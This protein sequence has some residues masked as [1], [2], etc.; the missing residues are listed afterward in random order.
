MKC[1]CIVKEEKTM[2]PLKFG[3]VYNDA[4]TF[5]TDYT[6]FG[7]P[8]T[9]SEANCK[10]LFYLLYGKYAA[11]HFVNKNLVQSKLKIF[12]TIFKYGPTWEKKLEIQAEL[13]ALDL[14]DLQEGAKQIVNHAN[15]PNTA[16][17]TTALE[18]LEFIDE[19]HQT[20]YKRNKVDAYG[21]LWNMLATD[22]TEEFLNRFRNIFAVVTD[23]QDEYYFT[24]EV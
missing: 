23:E 10:T 11:S 13:R 2:R 6:S 24:E 7:I 17:S 15:N 12:S 8:T 1:K 19:Q 20:N 9:I 14:A 22:V 5:Y 16:P 3:E 18:E 4:D 21:S